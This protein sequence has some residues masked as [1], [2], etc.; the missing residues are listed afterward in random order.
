METTK[1]PGSSK[2]MNTQKL[3]YLIHFIILVIYNSMEKC[4]LLLFTWK[5]PQ[6]AATQE[7]LSHTDYRETSYKVGEPVT[8]S[9]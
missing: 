4:L 5:L 2:T 9:L 1:L 7:S 3:E 8:R 6:C